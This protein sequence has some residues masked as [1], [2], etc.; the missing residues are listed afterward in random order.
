VTQPVLQKRRWLRWLRRL[1]LVALLSA[2]VLAAIVQTGL[3]EHWMRGAII[4]QL[5]RVTGGQ[6]ELRAFRFEFFSLRAELEGLAIRGTEPEGSPPLFRADS[7]LVDVRVV[8]LFDRK[9]ALDEVRLDK[10][11]VHV[12]MDENG[13]T[14]Y[15]GPKT[16]PKQPG[17]PLRE[18]IFDLSIANLRLNG[19]EVLL[20][21]V[22]VPL[23]AEGGAFS[24]SLG[25]TAPANG[26]PAYEGVFEWQRM[27][28]AARRYLPFPS[29][30]L[31]KF[32]LGRDS[33]EVSEFLWKLPRS[34]VRAGA[35]LA[36]FREPAWSF[37]Y[38]GRLSLED[39]RQILRKPNSP[40]GRVEFQG[41]G[42]YA[43]K[44]KELETRGRYVAREIGMPYEWFHAAGVESR[45]SFQVANRRVTIPD[46]RANVLGGTVQG[47]VTMAFDGL[48]W[49][50][51]TIAQGLDV[52]AMLHAVNH[53]GFPVDTLHWG[54]VAELEAVTTW[55][56]D[57]KEIESRG[58]MRWAPPA[59]PREGQIPVTAQLDYGYVVARKFA[60]LRGSFIA[61]PTSRIEM[62]GPLGARDS[63]LRVK[64]EIGDLLP[65]ND[66]INS[67]RGAEPVRITGRAQ[68]EGRILGHITEPTFT[69]PIRGTS[70][71]YAGISF[72]ALEGHITYSPQQFRFE[73]ARASRKNSA[74]SFDLTLEL[75]D[76][77][78]QPESKWSFQAALTRVDTDELQALFG[79]SYP[80]RGRLTGQFSGGGTRGN[81]ELRGD[82][83]VVE[84]S[85]W[86]FRFDRARGRLAVGRH[87]VR[88]SEVEMLLNG[89]KLG[90]HVQ[91]YSREARV[92]CDIAG[93]DIAIEK[94]EQ[95]RSE[96]VPLAGKLSFALQ[97]GGPL[98]APRSQG[99]LRLADLRAGEDLLGSFDG[100][101]QSDG[102]NVRVG[103]TSAMTTGGLEGQLALT[104]AGDYPMRGDLT[105][106][107]LDLDIFIERALRLKA[108]T[109][110]SSVDGRFQLSGALRKPETI[111]VDADISRLRF[112]YQYLKLENVGP[113]QFTY[114]NNEV[115]IRQAHIRGPDTDFQITGSAGFAQ[116]RRL[117]FDLAGTVN[118]QLLTGFFPD[119]MARGAAQ[120]NASVEGTFASPRITGRIR[121]EKA[122]ANYGEF[123]AG[124]SNVSGELV[125][126]R[127]RLLFENVSAEAGGGRMLLGGSLTYGE[128]P[129]RYDLSARATRV[130]V[131]YPE[132][133]SW[134]AGGTIRLSGTTR[135]GLLSG[136]VVIERL[137]M[138]EGFDLATLIVASREGPRAPATSS[139][140]LRN[141]QFDIEANSSPDARVEWSSARFDCDA[142]L[143]VRGTWEHPI[144][145]GHIRL[146]NGEMMFRGN[147]YRLTR[148][149][150]NFANP[151]RLVP[152]LN[153]EAVTTIR[154]YEI[155]LNFSGS[156]DK[157]TLAYRSDPPLPASD[158]V[159]LLALGRTGEESE[160]RS[161]TPVQSP[162]LGATT[163]LSEAIS[164]QIGGRVQRLFGISRFKVDPFLAGTGTE[165]NASARITVE[166]QLTRDLTITY[167]TNVTSTQQQVIQVEYAV[168]RE[169]SLIFLRDQNGTFG[170]DVKFK[171]RFR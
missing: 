42:R 9:I 153:V 76:W 13:R 23:V 169:V 45:G 98:W 96:R 11:Q 77:S 87:S 57:F 107:G 82:V 24:F 53:P 140:Y 95:L 14:N 162:E 66:F 97:G 168:N 122:A 129:L 116:A 155:T 85:A 94:I 86:G 81:P 15:P 39:L 135:S 54:G 120:V 89:G 17:R 137:L 67:I 128:G 40:Q 47:R 171:K 70:V 88:L 136:R 93:Q 159:A 61:T 6:V 38:Q 74:A 118:L 78:F 72:D 108:L 132:G 104:L 90:G 31:V 115:R 119:L 163:L 75:R 3:A 127:N 110:H 123:P 102:R 5:E 130:R 125:F 59:G 26:E 25:Y 21:N 161:P 58:A 34:E 63:A 32:R 117:D 141:L 149:D 2:L 79:T 144:L 152:A 134:L 83:D 100:T 68:W 52:N 62:D 145:L 20:N 160:L 69:G 126:D 55:A 43:A 22:R 84:G 28:M 65:W 167:I 170:L 10:P 41:E 154:Q 37:H 138:S 101:L 64:A 133:L 150:I 146:L 73:R 60:E 51:E 18:Q 124:L 56:A 27:R 147:R 46:F 91:Y 157:L 30:V 33:F 8:S 48:K 165:Q 151:F 166:Q 80:A 7:L 92:E 105:L 29:D 35:T 16:P 142:S 71:D 4:G 19:G 103:L 49:R 148:G 44:E 113:V 158:I 1:A 164:S 106:R 131:R 111:I 114:G 12:R 139:P 112:D 50:A 156:A 109:G 36:S 143:R 99:K 121:V